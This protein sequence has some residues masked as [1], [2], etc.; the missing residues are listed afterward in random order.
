MFPWVQTPK[1]TVW[2]LFLDLLFAKHHNLIRK[3]ATLLETGGGVREGGT[4]F[5]EAN[6]ILPRKKSNFVI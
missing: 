6:I 2:Y 4:F 1:Q 3:I 5:L